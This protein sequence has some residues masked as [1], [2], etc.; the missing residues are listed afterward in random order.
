MNNINLNLYIILKYWK[1]IIYELYAHYITYFQHFVLFSLCYI[2]RNF[3]F[4]NGLDSKQNMYILY[5][6]I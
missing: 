4:K 1:L 5:L 6:N 2:L 3:G